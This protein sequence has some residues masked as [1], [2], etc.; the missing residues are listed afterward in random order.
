MFFI[1]KVIDWEKRIDGYSDVIKAKYR[2]G[3]EKFAELQS[4]LSDPA[5]NWSVVVDN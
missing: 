1:E 4:V 2:E 5:K 3:V